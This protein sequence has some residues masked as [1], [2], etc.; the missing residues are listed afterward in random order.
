MNR[1]IIKLLR[2]RLRKDRIEK[3]EDSKIEVRVDFIFLDRE[4]RLQKLINERNLRIRDR[5]RGSGSRKIRRGV[6]NSRFT[7]RKL[8]EGSSSRSMYNRVRSRSRGMINMEGRGRGRGRSRGGGG[9]IKR[10][11]KGRI[12][13]GRRVIAN[14]P[15]EIRGMCVEEIGEDEEEGLDFVDKQ[16]DEEG[17]VNFRE[18]NEKVQ[19]QGAIIILLVRMKEK[20]K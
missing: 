13:R 19:D 10:R 9:R 7:R 18:D 1:D 2:S 20:M 6:L 16:T 12:R 3:S 5:S 8:Q 14:F 11:G 15:D 17:V 4:M